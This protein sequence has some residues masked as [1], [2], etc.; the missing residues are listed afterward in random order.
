MFSSCMPLEMFTRKA[1]EVNRYKV[2]AYNLAKENRLLKGEINELKYQLKSLEA[3]KKFIEIK[4]GEKMP[5]RR[6]KGKR[7][8]SVRRHY[9]DKS[10]DMVKFRTYNWPE[11]KLLVVGKKSFMAKDY[12]K[13]AQ[14][15]YTLFKEY[16][17]S[18]M[19]DDNILF[20]SGVSAFKSKKH[21]KWSLEVLKELVVKYPTSKF[22]RGAKLWMAL[23]HFKLGHQK[24]FFKIVED[25]RLK[26][27]NTK[28]WKILREYYEDF[29]EKY[30]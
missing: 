7:P 28:E 25:F 8:A 30:Q 9:I 14:Y 2:A 16:P 13:A 23:S 24:Q 29:S 26:Y 5:M 15:F 17:Q 20:L 4:L 27:R 1:E 12:E 19:I 11:K 22:Y 21:Y 18:K 3:E 10:K 6:G